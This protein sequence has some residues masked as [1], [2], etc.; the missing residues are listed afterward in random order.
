M[1]QGN[2]VDLCKPQSKS[3][4]GDPFRVALAKPVDLFPQVELIIELSLKIVSD[5]ASRAN[6]PSP[7]RW[8]LAKVERRN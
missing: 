4:R 1:A 7:P 6:I 5:A 2:I 3:L 8:C